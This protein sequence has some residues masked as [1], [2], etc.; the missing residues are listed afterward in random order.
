MAERDKNG[1]QQYRGTAVLANTKVNQGWIR[2]LRD[3]TPGHKCPMKCGMCVGAEEENQ[4]LVAWC[5]VT[6]WSRVCV[7]K[8]CWW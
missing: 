3:T 8:L 2:R 7:T 5:V 6:H 1:D 4:V